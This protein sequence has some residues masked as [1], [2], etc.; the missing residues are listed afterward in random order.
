M[1]QRTKD[2]LWFMGIGYL[3]WVFITGIIV[4]STY[5]DYIF[6]KEYLAKCDV[7]DQYGNC[8][9]AQEYQ[10]YLERE[11]KQFELPD[12]IFKLPKN[13]ESN[14]EMEKLLGL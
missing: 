11:K 14:K 3:V 5:K 4:H 12:W 7:M 2:I 8:M 1:N 10:D 13:K 9:T 6:E